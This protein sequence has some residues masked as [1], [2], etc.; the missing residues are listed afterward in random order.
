MVHRAQKSGLLLDEAVAAVDDEQDSTYEE[1]SS[2][3]ESESE[4]F[5]EGGSKKKVLKIQS[6]TLHHHI[7]GM[8]QEE[9]VDMCIPAEEVVLL[10]QESQDLL[11]DGGKICAFVW[12][13]SPQ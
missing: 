6:L 4:E 8:E 2:D 11:D 7:T 9:G 13:V 10:T 12:V 5:T 3:D 1:C